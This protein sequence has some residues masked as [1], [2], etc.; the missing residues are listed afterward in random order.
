MLAIY[1]KPPFLSLL[2]LLPP[3]PC[4]DCKGLFIIYWEYGTGVSGYGTRTFFNASEYG[5]QRFFCVFM[6]R[7]MNF[8]WEKNLSNYIL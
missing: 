7:D 8:F 2:K 6:V 5:T 1:S 4:P 3:S